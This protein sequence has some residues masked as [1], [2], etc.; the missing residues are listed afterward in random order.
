MLLVG[1][2]L[3]WLMPAASPCVC[4]DQRVSDGIGLDDMQAVFARKELGRP[5]VPRVLR[6]ALGRLGEWCWA[7]RDDMQPG[8]MYGFFKYPFEAMLGARRN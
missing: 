8:P 4:N 3:P 5:P 7:T 6:S 1:L 2:A